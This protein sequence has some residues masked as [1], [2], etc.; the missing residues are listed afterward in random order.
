MQEGIIELLLR[1]IEII[2][3]LIGCCDD[4]FD[5]EGAGE[6]GQPIQQEE[7]GSDRLKMVQ[8]VVVFIFLQPSKPKV[9]A[10]TSIL[11]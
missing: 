10:V 7:K 8:K 11:K 3:K 5:G 2:C 9:R 6:E 1:E 4:R